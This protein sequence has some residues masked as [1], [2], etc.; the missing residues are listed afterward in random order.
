MQNILDV[1]EK[2]LSLLPLLLKVVDG[3]KIIRPLLKKKP[4]GFGVCDSRFTDLVNHMIRLP[5]NLLLCR[6]KCFSFFSD[7]QA[8]QSG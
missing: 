7:S 3:N 2:I 6:G 8:V 1:E 4:L 5:V